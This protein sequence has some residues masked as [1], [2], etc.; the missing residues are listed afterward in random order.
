[1]SG[2]GSTQTRGVSPRVALAVI[3][4]QVVTAMPG[5]ALTSLGRASWQTVDRE[6]R[7]DGVTAIAQGDGRFELHLHVA[8]SWPP[9]PL[10]QLAEDLRRR[11]MAAAKRAQLAEPLGDVHVDI[12][13]IE[14]DQPDR[15]TP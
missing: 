13:A 9:E 10:P 2:T 1:M 4:D 14:T 15:G 11:V 6:Q 7:I 8:V 5:V 3:A 12:A